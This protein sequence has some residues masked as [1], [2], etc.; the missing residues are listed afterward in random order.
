MPDHWRIGK[1]TRFP[2]LKAALL[3]I[4]VGR[5]TTEE[6]WSKSYPGSPF[7][8]PG[9]DE[10]RERI[11]HINVVVSTGI[12]SARLWTEN[13][14][15]LSFVLWLVEI[16][17]AG[18]L[19]T[20]IATFC[21]TDPPANSALFPF[22][23]KDSYTLFLLSLGLSFGG[24]I[25]GSALV[26]VI[27]RSTSDW[28]CNVC[29]SVLFSFLPTWRQSCSNLPLVQTM[30][31][32]KGRILGTMFILSYPFISIG[33]ATLSFASGEFLGLA[34]PC[35]ADRPPSLSAFDHCFEV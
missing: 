34:R 3:F 15:L 32:T 11:A 33:L 17:Q 29:L 19:L 25:V 26:F 6:F 30:M 8:Q 20:T 21:T 18:L 10:M 13:R 23:R 35:G 2:R 24:L 5:R 7:Y 9:R 4:G 28:F 22:T 14:P 12:L 27:A 1:G 31:R 16:G